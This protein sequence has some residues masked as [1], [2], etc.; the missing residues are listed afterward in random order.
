[1]GSHE[2]PGFIRMFWAGNVLDELLSSH[3]WK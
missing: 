2:V 3:M 1:M